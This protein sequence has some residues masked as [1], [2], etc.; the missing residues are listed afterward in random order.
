MSFR[1][2][3]QSSVADSAPA[4]DPGRVLIVEDAE[5]LLERI[6]QFLCFEGHSVQT[7]ISGLEAM[8][9]V[10]Q[11]PPDIVLC[12]ALMPGMDGYEFSR[13]VKTDPASAHIPIIM[14]SA[15]GQREEVVRGLEFAEEYVT[16]PI[17]LRELKARVDSMMRLKRAQDAVRAANHKLEDTVRRRTARLRL[18]NARLAR[19]V[20]RREA[21]ESAVRTLTRRII[22]VREDE[23][24]A[25]AMDMHDDVGQCLLAAKLDLQATFARLGRETEVTADAARILERVGTITQRI[26]QISHSL[27][28]IGLRN[29]GLQDAIKNMVQMF[30]ESHPVLKIETELSHLDDFFPDSWDVN[31]YR[32]VQESLVN[33]MKHSHA[34]RIV[35]S[36]ELDGGRLTLRV[37][38]NGRGFES[39]AGDGIGLFVMQERALL[40]G[41]ECTIRSWTADSQV[42][43]LTG[44]EVQIDFNERT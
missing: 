20:R 15:R 27:S 32:I 30:M 14:I 9:C 28:P 38:D 1:E 39:A 35:V 37:R 13:R 19:E 12:D 18:S 23:R 11:C 16:K 36:D 17:D 42:N 34:T 3:I 7:A 8:E 24:G 33:S 21:T 44:T 26:R 2:I 41:G 6:A 5:V 40:S 31:L 4:I 43:G 25:L 10:K 22:T 29:L